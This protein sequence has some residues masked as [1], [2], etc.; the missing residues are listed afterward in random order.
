MGSAE[1][2]MRGAYILLDATDEVTGPELV[3]IVAHALTLIQ[4]RV[5]VDE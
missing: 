1:H 5:K 4:P 3:F 2:A